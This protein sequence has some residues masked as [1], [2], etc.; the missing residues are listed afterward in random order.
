MCGFA[1]KRNKMFIYDYHENGGMVKRWSILFVT[2]LVLAFAVSAFSATARIDIVSYC[3]V[4]LEKCQKQ[5]AALDL[6]E[7]KYLYDISVERLYFF[8]T[9]NPQKSMTHVALECASWQGMKDSY[10]VELESNLADLSRRAL[11]VYAGYVGLVM[12]NF[13]FCLDTQLSAWDVLDEVEIGLDDGVTSAPSI[14]INMDLYEGKQTFSSLEALIKQYLGL[15]DTLTMDLVDIEPIVDAVDDIGLDVSVIDG[16]VI[17]DDIEEEIQEDTG[18]KILQQAEQPLFF[19]I[20]SQFSSW[21][22]G[23]GQ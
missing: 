1:I 22:L 9:T 13:T 10:K 4:T 8:D 2:M 12:S 11:E 15:G 5:D 21:L 20:V 18:S 17:V 23:L 16:D 14:R 3:D 7:D 6:L 19:R